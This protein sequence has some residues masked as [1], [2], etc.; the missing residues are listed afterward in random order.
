MFQGE[1]EAKFRRQGIHTEQIREMKK[2]RW[3][4]SLRECER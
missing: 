1:I 3:A 2:R 4:Y